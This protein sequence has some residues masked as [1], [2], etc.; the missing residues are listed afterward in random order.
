MSPDSKGPDFGSFDDF[1]PPPKSPERRETT[2][3][4]VEAGEKRGFVPRE[5][6]VRKI[7]PRMKNRRRVGGDAAI[8]FKCEAVEFNRFV[9]MYEAADMGRVDFFVA[10][11]DAYDEREQLRAEI[12][13]LQKAPGAA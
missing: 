1:A 4:I 6:V 11:M 13:R 10:L 7:D 3:R 8:Y 5:A 12:A 2:K 9:E